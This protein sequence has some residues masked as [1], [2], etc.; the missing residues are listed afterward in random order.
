MLRA[1]L[2]CR[3]GS[4]DGVLCFPMLDTLNSRKGLELV[5]QSPPTV[6]L[7]I[8]VHGSSCHTT[9]GSYEEPY[10][11]GTR[12]KPCKIICKPTSNNIARSPKGMRKKSNLKPTVKTIHSPVWIGNGFLT[13]CQ[14]H[15]FNLSAHLCLLT[16][17]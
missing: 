13:R 6:V 11:T 14:S 12:G 3:T 9:S 7:H 8:T 16:L 4:L 1:K 15:W 2:M 10:E 17:K 5:T